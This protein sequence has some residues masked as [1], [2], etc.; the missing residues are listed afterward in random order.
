MVARPSHPE[1]G[2]RL[3]QEET[4]QLLEASQPSLLPVPRH[5]VL[6][7]GIDVNTTVFTS[8][9]CLP[10]YRSFAAKPGCP[11]RALR[12]EE[13]PIP[14]ASCSVGGRVRDLQATKPAS[15]R[16]SPP[17]GCGEEKPE[18]YLWV[19]VSR[20]AIGTWESNRPTP[21]VITLLFKC[22][23]WL[24]ALSCR[25]PGWTGVTDPPR[26]GTHPRTQRGGRGRKGAYQVRGFWC[27]I[28][29]PRFATPPGE[30]LTASE[31]PFGMQKHR[32]HVETW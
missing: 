19:V 15:A 3:R 27:G 24:G 4:L 12:L 6:E 1:S 32:R 30:S 31:V 13:I 7:E 25:G 8:V 14:K 5:H 18:Y 17:K 21:D 11:S 29:V 23:P 10:V 2:L 9:S 28:T 16:R 22:R 20:P 26:S